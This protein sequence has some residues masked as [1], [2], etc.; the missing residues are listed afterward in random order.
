MFVQ[1]TILGYIFPLVIVISLLRQA[2]PPTR[3]KYTAIFL[4]NHPGKVLEK[5]TG[6]EE[7]YE[8]WCLADISDADK[9]LF[10]R[11]VMEEKSHKTQQAIIW[12]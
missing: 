3:G 4:D 12:C 2:L 8:N 1:C 7:F 9:K 10:L 6:G 11:F 5:L